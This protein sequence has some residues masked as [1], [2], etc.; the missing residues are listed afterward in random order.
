MVIRIQDTSSD[1]WTGFD[2]DTDI[3]C[4][5]LPGTSV[6]RESNDD[7]VLIPAKPEPSSD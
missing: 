1:D 7:D 2:E 4:P 6:T 3:T 5:A